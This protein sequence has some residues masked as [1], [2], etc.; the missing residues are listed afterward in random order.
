MEVNISPSCCYLTI[1]ASKTRCW[2]GRAYL[3]GLLHNVLV[4][5]APPGSCRVLTTGRGERSADVTHCWEEKGGLAKML[6]GPEKAVSLDSLERK[7]LGK[8]VVEV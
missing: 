1:N 7:K 8:G 2:R 4:A 5:P 6:M 3:L